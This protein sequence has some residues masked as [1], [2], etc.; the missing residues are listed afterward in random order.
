MAQLFSEAMQF[1]LFNPKED[2][3][4]VVIKEFTLL[5]K[6]DGPLQR[7]SE[8]YI[9]SMAIDQYGANNP[10]ID[11]NILPYPKVRKGDV[12]D[13]GGQGHLIYGPANPG[14]F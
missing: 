5:K 2:K 12:I 14:E 13:F 10:A 8:P 3:I 1:D 9:V 6:A 7:Y 4:A 11:F